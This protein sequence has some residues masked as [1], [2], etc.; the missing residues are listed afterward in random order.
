MAND[1][2]LAAGATASA[3]TFD[4]CIAIALALGKGDVAGVIALLESA[5]TIELSELESEV[6][7]KMIAKAA[8]VRLKPLRETWA[9]ARA[10]AQRATW[11]TNARDRDRGA[12]EREAELRREQEVE[13]NRIWNSCRQIAESETLLQDMEAVVHALGLVGEAAAAR[14]IY[15]TCV[16]RLLSDE[17]ARLLRLGAPASGKNFAVEKVLTLIPPHAI[18]QFSGSS[19]K[20]L[21][22]F[23]GADPDALKHKIIYIPE[24]Q[25]LTERNGVENE[26]T[27]MLRTLISE[28][29]IVYQTVALHEGRTPETVTIVKNGP[30]AAIV[31]TARDIDPELK[32]R[33]LVV[34]ADERGDQTVNIAERI[35]SNS[36]AAAPDL[37]PWLELQAW[38]EMDS[39]YRVR[40]PFKEAIFGAFQRWRP[41]FLKEAA[42]RMRRDIPGFLN[43]I[44]A[45]AVVYRAQRETAV[46][47]TIIATLDDYANAHA[48]FDE[49]LAVVHGKAGEKVIAVVEAVAGIAGNA[50]DL[51]VKVT[52]RELA[53]RLRVAAP[54]TAGA[55]LAAAV[56]YGAIEQDDA[57]SGRGGARYYKILKTPEE[58]RMQPG[59]GVFP[60]VKYVADSFLAPYPLQSG[61]QNEQNEQRTRESAERPVERTKL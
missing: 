35:L 42:L 56:D 13:R 2:V 41:G 23:G 52:L 11:T 27:I 57:M 26:F 34:D 45:S 39:P 15:L 4:E 18:I 50:P 14:A 49:G 3:R 28:G 19:P 55:R 54:A 9:R 6:L 29:R 37:R 48:A 44:K 61:E 12:G 31:T 47:G 32:T 30:I 58:I 46:D 38:L 8:D 36:K 53:K 17:A 60:P 24:A 21:A 5:A 40:V 10:Q 22:Y 20:T 59:L 16:S 7:I 43:A 1:V 25:I 51:P 33:V